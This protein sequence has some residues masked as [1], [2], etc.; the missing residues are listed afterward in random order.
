MLED[1]AS[2]QKCTL[3]SVLLLYFLFDLGH[4]VRHLLAANGVFCFGLF[5]YRKLKLKKEFAGWESIGTFFALS[6]SI[7]FLR[8]TVECRNDVP[9]L[10]VSD[11]VPLDQVRDR[12]TTQVFINLSSRRHAAAIFDELDAVLSKYHG[13]KPVIFRIT[14]RDD[15]LA[16]VRCAANRSVDV[17][18]GFCKEVTGLLGPGS[19]QLCG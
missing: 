14:T 18:G 15:L 7:V 17:S 19:V 4:A 12:L 5:L 8:G 6:I 9:A 11:V 3:E 10:R 16:A 1:E 13:E 2:V